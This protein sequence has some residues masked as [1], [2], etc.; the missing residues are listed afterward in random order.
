MNWVTAFIPHRTASEI[1]AAIKTLALAAR[2]LDE[3]GYAA[4]L[5]ANSR[6]A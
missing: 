4:W 3:A 2:D 6:K 1:E 5:K